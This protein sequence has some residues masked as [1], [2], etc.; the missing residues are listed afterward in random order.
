MKYVD[1]KNL[2]AE[3]IDS[4]PKKSKKP[5]WKFL[6][7]V[8]VVILT[9]FIATMFFSRG[10]GSIFDPIS[11]VANVS[12]SNLKETDGRT[13]VLIMGLDKRDAGTVSSVLT[14]TLM[15][16][17]IGRVE[18]D[19]VLIS[20][21]RDLWVK[22]PNGGFSKIN[23]VYGYANRDP[24]A[25][26]QVVENVLGI[27]IHYYIVIDF[28]IFKETIDTLGG[29]DINV[30]GGFSDYEYPIENKETDRC[31]KTQE[32]IDKMI[33]EELPMLK[34]VP[35]RYETITFQAGTQ[36][37]NGET[38]LKY[39]RS[40][41]ATGTEGTDFARAKRQQNVITAAKSKALSLNTL[42]NP[43]KLKELYDTYS[44]N[45]QTNIDLPTMQSFYLLSQQV[46]F[47]DI[48]SIVLDDRSS[49]EVGGLLYSPTDTTL[50]GGK[51]VLIPRAGDFSQLHAYVQKYIFGTK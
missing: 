40:R 25:T 26:R 33:L 3:R 31:G 4:L 46:S 15:V 41:H 22:N 38:A 10:S 30:E 42:F 45:V 51:W 18:S 49:A 48:K 34:I 39:A 36:K 21:P 37:M 35:C 14:D 28:D 11:I 27:P 44:K 1:V 7:P 8:F 5:L 6:L 24:E 23:E 2:R 16:A 43:V 32:E 12:A 20:L 50:Y 47:N 9:A 17:S 19:V 29:I 13:N